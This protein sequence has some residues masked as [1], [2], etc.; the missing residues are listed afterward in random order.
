MDQALGRNS[1]NL[2]IILSHPK[3]TLTLLKYI[4]QMKRFEDSI[5]NVTPTA[6]AEAAE[7]ENK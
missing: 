4:G 1:R 2:K 7:A 3:S 5:G 6:A